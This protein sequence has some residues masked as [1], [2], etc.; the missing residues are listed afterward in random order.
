VKLIRSTRAAALLLLAALAG[1]SDAPTGATFAPP[2]APA[3]ILSASNSA[4]YPLVSWDAVPGATSYTVRFV[5]MLVFPGGGTQRMRTDLAT[6]TG[7]SYLDTSRVYTGDTSCPRF[8]PQIGP[9]TERYQYVIVSY[10][11]S[12]SSMQI[13]DAPVGECY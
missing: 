2:E 3:L 10:H 8:E 13:T 7:T 5:T 9:Y 11:A 6:T 1:C 12:G 4:G